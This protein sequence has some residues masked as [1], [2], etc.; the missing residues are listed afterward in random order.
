MTEEGFAK[1]IAFYEEAAALDETYAL[2]YTSIAEYYIHVG[3]QCLR[4]FAECSRR[5]KEA[6][7]KAVKFD[8]TSLKL[9][10]RS[11]LPR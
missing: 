8:P 2:A 4:P 1:A 11:D 5:A 10:Q 7:E 6:A 9:M 3:I